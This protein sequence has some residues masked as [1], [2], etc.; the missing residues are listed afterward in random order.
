MGGIVNDVLELIFQDEYKRVQYFFEG[1]VFFLKLLFKGLLLD[2][3]FNILF[4][5]A[6]LKLNRFYCLAC[7]GLF[8]N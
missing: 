8:F 3:D 1:M 6:L 7:S 2:D 5:K 4:Q